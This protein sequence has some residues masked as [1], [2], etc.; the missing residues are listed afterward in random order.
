MPLDRVRGQPSDILA[1]AVNG[2]GMGRAVST[3]SDDSL[4]SARRDLLARATVTTIIMRTM[5]LAVE[6]RER[7]QLPALND[8]TRRKAVRRLR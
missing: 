6:A 3:A 2:P 7:G 4:G 5:T 8:L 1:D